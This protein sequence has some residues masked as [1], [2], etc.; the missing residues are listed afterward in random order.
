MKY[1]RDGDDRPVLAAL[2][3]ARPAPKQQIDWVRERSE[4]YIV[5]SFVKSFGGHPEALSRYVEAVSAAFGVKP[6]RSNYNTELTD[7]MPDLVAN[8]LQFMRTMPHTADNRPIPPVEPLTTFEDLLRAIEILGGTPADIITNVVPCGYSRAEFSVDGKPVSEHIRDIAA[9]HFVVS[10]T[11]R[12][13]TDRAKVMKQLAA[14]PVAGDPAFLDFLMESATAG[15][16]Q[17]RAAT[18]RLLEFQSND[19]VVVRAI[20]MLDARA[21]GT[22]ASAV[23]ILGYI[24]SKPAL[25]AMR[26][27]AEVEKSQDVLT[28]INHFV[29]ASAEPAS[30]ALEGQYLAADDTLVDIPSY[31]PLAETDEAPFGQSDLEE[32]IVLDEKEHEREVARY[33]KHLELYNA[34]D[35]WLRKRPKPTRPHKESYAKRFL[36]T[37]NTP[38]KIEPAVVDRSRRG[39]S[40]RLADR[41]PYHFDPWV[42]KAA[43]RLPDLR[44]VALTLGSSRDVRSAMAHFYNPYS[45]ELNNRI[46]D[47][48]IDIRQVLDVAR[49]KRLSAGDIYGSTEY[50]ASDQAGVLALELN[51]RYSGSGVASLPQSWPITAAHLDMVIDALPPRTL[52]AHR[53]VRALELLGHLPKLPKSAIDT[54]LYTALDDRLR[55]SERAQQ[56]LLNVDGIDARLIAALTDKRQAVRARA[57]RFLADRGH[58][59]AVPALIKRLKTEKSESAKADLISAV[60]RLGGDTTPYLGKAALMKEAEAL[61]K[62]LPNAKLD[63]LEMATAPALKWADGK[64]VD[65]VVPDAW[66][67]L[68][69]K[70]KSPGGSPLFGLYFDQLDPASVTAFCDWLLTSW[71]SY[72][73]WKPAT[74]V[75]RE[76]AY[77]DAK[78]RKASRHG[79]YQKYTVD[80]IVAMFLPGM[81][82]KYPNSGTDAK[83]I[84]A[85]THRATPDKATVAIASYLKAHGKRVSQAKCLVEVLTA[86]GKPEALQVLVATA[87]RFKQRTVRELAEACVAQVAEERG[88]SEDELADRSIPTGGIEEDGVMLLEVGEEAKSYSARLASDLTVKL[89]N[90][91]GKEVKA[92]PA[93]KDDNT[94]EAKKLLSGAKKTVKTVVGQQAARLYDAMIGTRKWPIADWEADLAGHP[95]M[96]RLIER[97]I[98]RGLKEDGS[99][100]V[101]F[102]PTP[103]GD[104]LT[105]DGDDADLSAVA[106]VDIAHTATVDEETRQ[107][108]LSHLED[109]EVTP[110]FPQISRPMRVLDEKEAKLT[111]I[112]DRKG[113]LTEAFKL[114]S[115]T[116]KAGF[117]RGPVEDGAGFYLYVK[118]FRN[119][120]VRAE[121]QFTGSYVP[122]ENI[123]VAII[124]LQFF[125]MGNRRTTA[126]ELGDVP[127]MVL[128]EAWNDLHEIASVGAFD[129]DWEKKG[130]Y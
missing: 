5:F 7:D 90:P 89:F 66:L 49:Q 125:K 60:S 117:E 115:A 31:E 63:W 73:S 97:V 122:E 50:F 32:L 54:V 38:A 72:D 55:I 62:K 15:S 126:M 56:L 11:R 118:E 45:A 43:S 14:Y 29:G 77:K 92:L 13:A 41:H 93:G 83:G 3:A 57:A 24:G 46:L 121:L 109:F 9:E 100:A 113:W 108:W 129:S 75:L 81:L 6:Y 27:R 53:N 42:R 111:A 69:L 119:A 12:K 8:L 58:K 1:V 120:G 17:V 20:P 85:L 21:A 30:D 78:Q 28:A 105:A 98:W 88:W 91:D 112:E 22:R 124:D 10:L 65:P 80:E 103:E 127:A 19:E 51:E 33:E 25:D 87:T 39:A 64:P 79:W 48:T 96:V 34:G 35:K 2:S 86:M 71:I 68:A 44:L 84:L 94:K 104:R 95:I 36:E 82:S 102:R 26:A 76:Q 70:L 47:G 74:D 40:H 4:Q 116:S 128:S 23:Q 59:D 52:E 106:Y 130:L 67:R 123:P 18:H 99:V 37:L 110:L 107:A 101:L 61:A 16:A 114:R